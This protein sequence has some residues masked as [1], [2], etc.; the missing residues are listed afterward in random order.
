MNGENRPLV[1]N[2]PVEFENNRSKFK[3][4]GNLLI[5]LDEFI[6]YTSNEEKPKDVNM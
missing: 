1:T 6:K 4:L 2:E 3:T 5:I